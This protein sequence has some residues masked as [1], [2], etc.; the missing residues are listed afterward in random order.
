MRQQAVEDVFKAVETKITENSGEEKDLK[1]N[2]KEEL[3][4]TTK[5]V[6]KTH[7]EA[8][9]NQLKKLKHQKS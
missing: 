2:F 6:V 9:M 8:A 1:E 3:P 5:E 7:L 4:E